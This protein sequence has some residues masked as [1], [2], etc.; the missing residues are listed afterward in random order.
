MMTK[1]LALLAAL[2]ALSAP[3]FAGSYGGNDRNCDQR[4]SS[5]QYTYCQDQDDAGLSS[6]SSA[7]DFDREQRRLDEK[8]DGNV[9]NNYGGEQP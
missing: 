1:S 3:A 8:N 5:K 9:N 6:T 2:A 7:S 4:T